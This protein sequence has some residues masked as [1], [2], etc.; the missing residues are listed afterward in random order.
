MHE[1][2]LAQNILE[3]VDEKIKEKGKNAVTELI[4]ES[5]R[6]SGVEIP[7]L[8]YALK[9]IKENSILQDASIKV[10]ET[11]AIAKC[12]TC[13][14]V[15]TINSFTDSCPKCQSYDHSMQQG[16]QLIVKSI[17]AQ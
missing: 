5:G 15:F 16:D 11:E 6:L 2:S 14:N 3:I 10:I 9:A 17:T 8:E 7:A 1:F 12:A 13:L 4:L